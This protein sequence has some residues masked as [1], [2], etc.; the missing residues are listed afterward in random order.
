MEGDAMD[1]PPA[2]QIRYPRLFSPL[3]VKGLPLRNRVVMPPMASNMG[4]TSDQALAYYRERARGGVGMVI[5]EGT[6]VD[7]F[8]A[9]EFA[10]GLARLARALRAEGAASAI[11][12]VQPPEFDGHAV[13]VSGQDDRRAAATEEVARI[14][15]NF[16]RAARVAQEAGFDGVEIHGAHGFFLNH[17]FG[18][19]R[20]TRADRYGGSLEARR[21]VGVESVRAVRAATGLNFLVMYRHTPVDEEAGY[22]LAD[23]LPFARALE[24]ADLDVL[25][26]SPSTAPGE[27]HA[28]LAGALRRAVGVPIIAVGGLGDPAAAEAALRAGRADLVAIGRGLIAD[29]HW[30]AKVRAGREA[31]I[32]ECRECDEK[33]YGNLREGIPISCVQNPDSGFEYL[34]SR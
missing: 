25:D 1:S 23:S 18:P 6:R 17:F 14:P 9:P 21:R 15:A 10:R 29:A 13:S 16:A 20:N 11:Q 31:E 2:G 27:E 3:E 7:L 32:I 4:V 33:C 5:V 24:A 26:V 8:P 34:S 28:G 19:A 12:L 22:Q 30:A